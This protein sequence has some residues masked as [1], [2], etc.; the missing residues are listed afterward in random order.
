MKKDNPLFSSLFIKR[1]ILI[2]LVL[3]TSILS[4]SKQEEKPQILDENIPFYSSVRIGTNQTYQIEQ[5]SYLN[6]FFIFVFLYSYS[7][8]ANL[9]VYDTEF[10]EKLIGQFYS[11]GNKQYYE[12]YTDDS[13]EHRK[14][15]VIVEGVDNCYYSLNYITSNLSKHHHFSIFPHEMSLQT[16]NLKNNTINFDVLK[17]DISEEQDFIIFIHSLNCQIQTNFNGESYFNKNLDIFINHQY[18]KFQGKNSFL[19]ETRLLKLDSGSLSEKEMCMFY[20]TGTTI[21]LSSYSIL[22][23]EGVIHSFP[24]NQH[25]NSLRFKFP[26]YLKGENESIFISINKLTEGKIYVSYYVY[27][28]ERVGASHTFSLNSRKNRKV[29]ISGSSMTEICELGTICWISIKIGH[30]YKEN[31]FNDMLFQIEI[32]TSHRVPIFLP[33]GEMRLD[34]VYAFKS[35]HYYSNIVKNQSG[36]IVIHLKRGGALVV[37]KIVPLDVIEEDADWNGRI[38][39]PEME[40]CYIRDQNYIH[41]DSFNKKLVFNETHTKDCDKGCEIYIGIFSSDLTMMFGTPIYDYSIFIRSDDTIVSIPVNEHV[42]G[43]LAKTERENEY[44]YFTIKIY[45]KSTNIIFDFNGPLCGVYINFGGEKPTTE[46]YDWYIDGVSSLYTISSSDPKV[47]LESFYGRKITF[48][49]GAKLLDGE[50]NSYYD[51][52]ITTPPN[53]TSPIFEVNSSQNEHCYIGND[54][55]K[56][57]FII[58]KYLYDYVYKLHLYA[59]N[60]INQENSNIQIYANIFQMNNFDSLSSNVIM[61]MFPTKDRHNFTSIYNL[62]QN[63]LQVD[64]LG[65]GSDNYLLITITSLEKGKITLLSSFHTPSMVSS[66]HPNTNQLFSL[67]HGHKA[68]YNILGKDIYYLEI[69][70]VLGEGKARIAETAPSFPNDDYDELGYNKQ[71]SLAIVVNPE[72]SEYLLHIE[73]TSPLFIYYIRYHVRSKNENLDEVNFGRNTNIKYNLQ[74][75]SK[76]KNLFPLNYYIPFSDE[77][78]NNN[79]EINFQIECNE[80]SFRNFV[81][82]SGTV[83]NYNFIL[84]RKRNKEALPEIGELPSYISYD[85]GLNIGYLK[86]DGNKIKKY[87]TNSKKIIFFSLLLKA[88]EKVLKSINEVNVDL[89]PL[90]SNMMIL[91]KNKYFVSPGLTSNKTMFFMKKNDLENLYFKID[92]STLETNYTITINSDNDTYYS[93]YYNQE[94][95]TNQTD[96]IINENYSNGKTTLIIKLPYLYIKTLIFTIYKLDLNIPNEK[97]GYTIGFYS[98]TEN[99]PILNIID[100]T[101]QVKK[102]ENKYTISL[103]PVTSSNSNLTFNAY[104]SLRLF[105]NTLFETE[106]DLDVIYIKETPIRVYYMNSTS[107]SNNVINFEINDFPE[108]GI[109]ISAVVTVKSEKLEN[110]YK[111]ILCYKTTSIGINNKNELLENPLTKLLFIGLVIIFAIVLFGF[112]FLYNMYRNIEE[113]KEKER[114]ELYQMMKKP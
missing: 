53:G 49:V 114:I 113:S 59:M 32:I 36:E 60:D 20:I 82:I 41:F 55:D 108:G 86:F 39:L 71:K 77:Y 35:N 104:Y 79:I 65:F 38:R 54:S 96:L 13:N 106:G 30:D 91:P 80:K 92:F 62:P 64:F 66:L 40:D 61:N 107:N 90:Q 75:Y 5:K 105:P 9:Y 21:N 19:I 6:F 67:K 18:P 1:Y 95:K 12:I 73:S 101:I 98:Y 84:E 31:A 46:K 42:F 2:Y 25:V 15:K 74:F 29:Q 4:L 43:S 89:L 37:A 50:Y 83:T 3:L 11:A 16:L 81:D 94:F 99:Y 87:F 69:V 23:D 45:Q 44:D 56:C 27:E 28:I 70:Q 33:F 57:Y 58:P 88:E 78:S 112:C 10:G 110:D 47:N 102:E 72:S 93:K 97:K 68:I 34:V 111:E 109:Y 17:K 76:D 22:L 7:G 51:L 24:L 26:F 63:Y 48:A 52:K 8:K 14:L 100:N 103:N 85:Q